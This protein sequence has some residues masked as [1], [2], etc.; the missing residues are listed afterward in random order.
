MNDPVKLYVGVMAILLCVIGVVAY[1]SYQ[2]AEAYDKAILAAPSD[3]AKIRDYGADVIALCRQLETSKIKGKRP[4]ALVEEML[5]LNQMERFNRKEEP[6]RPV[7]GTNAKEARIKVEINRQT[8]LRRHQIAKL[9]RDVELSSNGILKTFELSL[10][11]YAGAGSEGA[12]KRDEAVADDS[13]VGEIYFG[14]RFV[15]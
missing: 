8:P 2:R 11:R 15:E 4:I 9:C 5:Q 14:Y 1:S 12:G 10:R 6:V 7:R 13:Y 3:A